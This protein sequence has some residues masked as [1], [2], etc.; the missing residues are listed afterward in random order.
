MAQLKTIRTT[1]G[2]HLEITLTTNASLL[3]RK[4]QALKQAG[5]NRLT[6]SLDALDDGIFQSMNDVNFPLTDVLAGLEAAQD[7]GFTRIKI[8]MVVKR[9]CNESQILPMVEH[10]MGSGHVLR[11]IEFMDVG[12]TNG[13]RMDDVVSSKELL[14]K[15][16][17]QYHVQLLPP[18]SAGETAQRYLLSDPRSQKTL[19]IGLISSVTQAFCASCNRARL[20][21]EGKLYLCLFA[22]EGYDLRSLLRSGASDESILADITQ[23]WAKRQDRYSELRSLGQ[24]P[25]E[26]RI[27][28]S[29]I[30][31]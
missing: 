26:R 8:N 23:I 1:S 3:V 19:E 17:S 21:T 2:H 16:H 6:V 9:Q 28:M 20:S 24:A 27:E 13:W 22:H 30:G 14:A 18:N 31:G 15:L 11:F 10:F 12:A 25:T 7:C 29:Y 4:A 5:L